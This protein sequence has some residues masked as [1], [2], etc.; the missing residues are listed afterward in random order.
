MQAGLVTPVQEVA[1][2]AEQAGF[3][4]ELASAFRSFERQL[5]IWN[6]KVSGERPVLNDS[7]EPLDIT[8][9]SERELGWA[10]LRWSAL[11]GTAR[12]HWGTELD[13]YDSSRFASCYRLQLPF[14]GT[15]ALGPLVVY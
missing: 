15:L 14:D 7:G 6:A 11:P 8:R 1:Q 4:F 9:L 12:H 5:E 10:I 3:R 13:V 2:A